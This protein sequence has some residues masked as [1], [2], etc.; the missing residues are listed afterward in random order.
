MLDTFVIDADGADVV[1]ILHI[2]GQYFGLCYGVQRT[3]MFGA[4]GTVYKAIGGLLGTYKEDY[5]PC[6]SA[7]VYMCEQISTMSGYGKEGANTWR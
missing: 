7:H 3:T 4:A 1:I 5:L 2:C 6:P